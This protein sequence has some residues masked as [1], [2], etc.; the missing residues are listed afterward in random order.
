LARPIGI[1][2]S[3]GSERVN[4]S[5]T[6]QKDPAISHQAGPMRSK[7]RPVRGFEPRNYFGTMVETIK[8]LPL[9]Q[10]EIRKD[11]I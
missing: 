1:A 11:E 5:H 8:I 2:T 7:R 3:F 6:S 10:I 9:P 4:L